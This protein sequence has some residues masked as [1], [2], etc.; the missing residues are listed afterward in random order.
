[1]EIASRNRWLYIAGS[2]LIVA[3]AAVIRIRGAQNDLWLDEIWSLHLASLISRPLGVFTQIHHDN[4][5]YLNTLWLYC[6]GP[7]RD[8]LAYRAPSILAGIGTIIL[9]GFIGRQRD[10]AT[11]V[12]AMVLATASYVLILYS[13]EA[14]GYAAVIFFS[15]L[16]YYLLDRYLREQRPVMALLFSFCAVLGVLFHLIFLNFYL[17][18]LVWSAIRLVRSPR[19]PKRILW[20]MLLCHALPIAFLVLIYIVDVRRIHQGG[21]TSFNLMHAAADCLAWA[22]T[23]PAAGWMRP[24][25]SLVTLAVFGAGMWL[26]WRERSNSAI[27]FIGVIVVVPVA[28]AIISRMEWIYPRHFVISIAFVLLLFSFTLG[29]LWKNGRLGK[30]ICIAALAV[31]CAANSFPLA[32]LFKDGHGHYRE[33]L[34]Y[35][36]AHSLREAD[37]IGGDHDFRI[38]M[39]LQFY[40]PEAMGGRLVKYY[41]S[42]AWPPEGPEWIIRH[43]ESLEEPAPAGT[44]LTDNSGNRYELVKTFP[45][46][47][48]SGLHWYL[49]HN[50][51]P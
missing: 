25:T 29:R 11:A 20:G 39:V 3:L 22:V 18:A 24:F 7:H 13:C 48:L 10:M 36:A 17:A 32:R 23:P 46:A 8:P 43:K 27:F 40:A 26:L 49:Y 47:P 6:L 5:N 42:D 35:I 2:I 4:N 12:F 15:F 37:T 30:A 16:S 33:A 34:R 38:P 14:R 28:L 9:A 51:A 21:G 41:R 50:L 19:S 1:M 45:T 44:S 31:Y